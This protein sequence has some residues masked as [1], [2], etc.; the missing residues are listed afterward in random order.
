MSRRSVRAY[1]AQAIGDAQSDLKVYPFF[2]KDEGLD[3]LVFI[4]RISSREARQT[5]PRGMGRKLVTY[6]L[7]LM[8]MTIDPDE[9]VAQS[10]MDDMLTEVIHC[11]RALPLNTELVDPVN[12]ETSVIINIGE[13]IRVDSNKVE[14]LMTSQGAE[15][16]VL[17]G[18]MMTFSLQESVIA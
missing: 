6:D 10:R 8:V 7:M 4:E 9:Q 12:Q 18:S 1:V 11:V 3:D 14:Q 15:A 5:M 13:D 16:V 17:A 2:P